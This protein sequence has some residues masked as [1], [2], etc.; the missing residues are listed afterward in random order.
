[1][2]GPGGNYYAVRGT[3][4]LSERS[5]VRRG[6]F[7][8]IVCPGLAPTT[9]PALPATA[10]SEPVHGKIAGAPFTVRSALATVVRMGRV[11]DASIIRE[12]VLYGAAGVTCANRDAHEATRQL[13]VSQIGG[14]S[15]ERGHGT[16][17]PASG[18]AIAGPGKE[19]SLTEES[20]W[21]Q[22]DALA[23]TTGATMTGRLV[24]EN[25]GAS[26]A[27]TFRATVCVAPR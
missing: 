22:L 11:G 13:R 24:V 17:Q 1:M 25:P 12:F 7:D 2:A 6:N 14:A 3:I 18:S 10:P 26:L 27:G 19:A 5:K 23:F 16:P 4:D 21:V 8:A 15:S 9:S 20:I